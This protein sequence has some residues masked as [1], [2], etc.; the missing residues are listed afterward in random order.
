VSEA[1]S[2]DRKIV[3]FERDEAGDWVAQLECGHTR[4]VRHRPPWEVREW[5]LTEEGRS[6]RLGVPLACRACATGSTD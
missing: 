6:S 1:S 5:V 4:H 3:G 2:S